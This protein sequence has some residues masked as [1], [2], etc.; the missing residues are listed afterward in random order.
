[1]LTLNT[2]ACGLVVTI[3]DAKGRAY[4]YR[5]EITAGSPWRC[6][7]VKL[8]ADE[9]G[10]VKEVVRHT[11]TKRRALWECSCLDW[12]LRRRG[13][14]S[15]CKHIKIAKKIYDLTKLLRTL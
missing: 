4:D 3:P 14:L 12:Q 15:D 8:V 10:E 9:D 13:L 11:V 6:G 1:M 5:V 2:T 7:L